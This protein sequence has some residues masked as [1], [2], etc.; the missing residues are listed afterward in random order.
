MRFS[1][2]SNAETLI[3][4]S[5]TLSVRRDHLEYIRSA[6]SSGHQPFVGVS[7]TAGERPAHPMS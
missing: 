5:R 6:L 1:A 4:L 3:C 7:E 2:A